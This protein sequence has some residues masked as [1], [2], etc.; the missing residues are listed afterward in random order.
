MDSIDTGDI[1]Q[2]LEGEKNVSISFY[3]IYMQ[4]HHSNIVQPL[5]DIKQL[6]DA[7]VLLSGQEQDGQPGDTADKVCKPHHLA[8]ANADILE[9]CHLLKPPAELRVEIGKLFILGEP[10]CHTHI[11]LVCETMYGMENPAITRVCR[12]LRQELLEVFYKERLRVTF[13]LG[14]GGPMRARSFLVITPF[15]R[16]IGDMTPELRRVL[17]LAGFWVAK[18]K[19]RTIKSQEEDLKEHIWFSKYDFKFDDE[20]LSDEEKAAPS[21]FGDDNDTAFWAACRVRLL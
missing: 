4:S 17:Y 7:E 19:R 20:L 9:R 1:G 5:P 11:G 15:E 18:D 21:R 12:V 8:L 16:W 10:T 13:P 3:L 2:E 6:V 14:W